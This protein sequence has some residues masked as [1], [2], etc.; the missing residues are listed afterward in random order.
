MESPRPARDRRYDELEALNRIAAVMADAPNPAGAVMP[1]LKLLESHLNM[2]HITL[3]L[4][5]SGAGQVSIDLAAD[6]TSEQIVR[7]RYRLGEGVTGKVAATGR[8]A[9]IPS[10]ADCPDFL[11]RTTQ[12]CRRGDSSFVCVPVIIGKEI[13]GTISMHGAIRPENELW[14]CARLLGTVA[15]MLAQAIRLRREARE[16]HAALADENE[17]LRGRLKNRVA[18]RNIIGKSR[19]MRIVFDQIAQAASSRSTVLVNG[20]TGTGKEL[21]AEALHYNGDRADKPFVK[22][23]CAAL[24]ESLIESELFGHEKGAFTGAVAR[25]QGRFEQADGGTIFLDEI[26]DIS[27]LMQVKLLRVLQEREFERVGGRETIKID[28]RVIAATH[29]DLFAMAR[30]GRFRSD[31]FYR[32]NVFPIYLLPLRRRQSDIPLL[33]EFFLDKYARNAGKRIVSIS[34]EVMDILSRHAWPGNVREL[35]NC[36]EHAVILANGS[37][38]GVE[39]LPASLRF[40]ADEP[41]ARMD[42]K[43]QVESFERGLIAEAL[44]ATRGNLSQAAGLLGTTPRIIAYRSRQ[45]GLDP[46]AFSTA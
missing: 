9:V 38:I 14:E 40:P 28:V 45:L 20:E 6:L 24:P 25:R 27:Q 19:E 22:V 2:R 10:I 44:R 3:A 37:S 31:L 13:L 29:R 33:A 12:G 11:A 15:A 4:L 39:H 41:G 21:V 26:G 8:P 16:S 30:E 35:E 17:R 1:A 34:P 46:V 32:I 7:G 43:S 36:I 18:P 5:D 42:F 23:N